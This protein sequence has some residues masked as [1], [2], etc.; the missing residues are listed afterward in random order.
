MK[1]QHWDLRILQTSTGFFSLLFTPFATS[2]TTITEST[3]VRFYGY[4]LQNLCERLYR[5]LIFFPLYS[6]A[7][8]RS[9]HRNPSLSFDF[10][11]IGSCSLQILF[12]FTAPA[13]E[14]LLRK[15]VISLRQSS[16]PASG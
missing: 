1:N 13:S 5:M 14:L 4:L 6:N 3:A 15:E 12:D 9:R 10:H 11:K 8:T 16:F 2:I 7:K